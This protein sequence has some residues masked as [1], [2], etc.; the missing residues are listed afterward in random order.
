MSFS[1]DLEIF[2]KVLLPAM[3]NSLILGLLVAGAI[4]AQ[5]YPT[6]TNAYAAI[7]FDPA[8]AGNATVVWFSDAHMNL[9]PYSG[10]SPA[11]TTNLDKR[12]IDFVN[13]LEPRPAKIIVSGDVSTSYSQ[14]PGLLPTG[15]WYII[16]GS[17]EMACFASAVL[18]ITNVAQTDIIWVPGNHDQICT[19]TNAELF[20]TMFPDMPPYQMVDV[21]NVRFFLL[22]SGNYGDPGEAQ[23]EWLK[24][25]VA[26]T[27]PTQTVAVVE[28]FPPFN[29]AASWRS[30]PLLFREAFRDWP[31]RLWSFSG[32]THGQGGPEVYDIGSKG[33][34][35]VVLGLSNTNMG[36]GLTHDSGFVILCL[37]NGISGVVY[38]HF[39]SGDFQVLPNADWDHPTEYV[40]G[41]EKTSGLLWRRLKTRV[42]APE[43]LVTNAI[44]SCFWWAYPEE[45]QWE[46]PLGRHGNQATH[47]LLLTSS[48]TY[49]AEVAFSEDRTNWVKVPLPVPP[50]NGVFE[51]PIPPPLA[52]LEKAYLKFAASPSSGGINGVAGWGLKSTNHQPLITF[53]QLAPI[54]DQFIVAGQIF[55]LTINAVDPYAPP[56]LLKYRLLS[57]PTGLGVDPQTGVITW[58]TSHT[59][60]PL[61]A[62][63][64]VQ[65]ADNGTP[66]MG[67][68]QQFTVTVILPSAPTLSLLTSSGDVH[69]FQ[70]DG[71]PSLNYTVWSSTN[72][73]TGLCFMKLIHQ[74]CRLLLMI[75]EPIILKCSTV[76][77]LSIKLANMQTLQSDHSAKTLRLVLPLTCSDIQ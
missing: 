2:V 31:S 28:H 16:Y 1:L 66:E 64:I 67:A 33:M 6:L 30:M 17:N 46:L 18:E 26:E 58:Q 45:L 8:A 5:A 77:L 59:N 68:T 42:R 13:A 76:L 54:P 11:L 15:D 75:L 20:R 49:D 35:G 36:G 51:I 72:F 70:V 37:S 7:G 24:A 40:A 43:N 39:S 14:V 3:G 10:I 38:Q 41:F 55:R 69:T 32:H 52:A 23:S 9:S 44:D 61:T 29:G 22:N 71:D 57:G 48:V 50:T 4:S 60:A 27:S 12:L 63:V 62:T 74:P 21:A 56:D 25:R 34:C 65:V 47:A 73:R 53:P 19:E